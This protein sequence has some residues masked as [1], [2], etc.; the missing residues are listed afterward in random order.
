MVAALACRPVVTV[1]WTEII[2]LAAIIVFA[3]SPFLIRVFRW[4]VRWEEK[5]DEE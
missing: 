2:I 5:Q 1:G 3:I 4:Y